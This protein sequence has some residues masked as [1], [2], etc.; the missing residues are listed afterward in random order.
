MLQEARSCSPCSPGPWLCMDAGGGVWHLVCLQSSLPFI[1][2]LASALGPRPPQFILFSTQ[3]GTV[4]ILRDRLEVG[5]RMRASRLMQAPEV[6][7]HARAS[8]HAGPRIGYACARASLHAGP[9]IGYACARASP[10]AGPCLDAC[11][12]FPASFIPPAV[13]RAPHCT[14]PNLHPSPCLPV[15]P[16]AWMRICPRLCSCAFTPLSTPCRP[17]PSLCRNRSAKGALCV[18]PMGHALMTLLQNP[19]APLCSLLSRMTH[20][21]GHQQSTAQRPGTLFSTGG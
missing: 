7:M 19:P 8:L 21:L 13:C 10:H 20:S 5:V 16:A 2:E 9:R 18:P 6:G 17:A 11:P 1:P 15:S 12:S 4:D 14:G 3:E